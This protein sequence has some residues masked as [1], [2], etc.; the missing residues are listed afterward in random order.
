MYAKKQNIIYILF[1]TF[2]LM[3]SGCSG[4]GSSSKT[5]TE[6]IPLAD[7]N[8]TFSSIGIK[9]VDELKSKVLAIGAL[10]LSVEIQNSN[11]GA[12]VEDIV[13]LLKEN[14]RNIEYKKLEKEGVSSSVTSKL[15]A[16]PYSPVIV[17]QMVRMPDEKIFPIKNL[18]DEAVEKLNKIKLGVLNRKL[19]I[20]GEKAI[21]MDEFLSLQKAFTS[22]DIVNNFG[23]LDKKYQNILVRDTLSS[24]SKLSATDTNVTEESY[25]LINATNEANMSVNAGDFP[26]IDNKCQIMRLQLPLQVAQ[27]G[28]TIENNLVSSENGD[29]KV[30]FPETGIAVITLSDM[31]GQNVVLKNSAGDVLESKTLSQ[32][33]QYYLPITADDICKPFTF[34]GASSEYNI[35]VTDMI[36]PQRISKKVFFNG[37]HALVSDLDQLYTSSGIFSAKSYTFSTLN[38]TLQN[39]KITFETIG[40][41]DNQS[42]FDYIL[43]APGGKLY[44]ATTDA[45]VGFTELP[46]LVRETGIWRLDI[47]PKG[48]VHTGA[49][50][51]DSI[52]SI[53][54]IPDSERY[55]DLKTYID[56]DADVHTKE[57]MLGILKSVSLKT[58]GEDGTFDEGEV[59]INLNTNM[60]PIL[61]VPSYMDDIIQSG[62]TLNKDIAL[63]QCWEK[64]QK[65]GT[66][67]QSGAECENFHDEF[68][69]R[70]E[71]YET[72]HTYDYQN[73][74]ETYMC[75]D[76]DGMQATCIKGEHG[77]YNTDNPSAEYKVKVVMRD[78][79]KYMQQQYNDV[80]YL[81]ILSNY[82]DLYQNWLDRTV[83][84]DIG[85]FP[86]D[87]IPYKTQEYMPCTSDDTACIEKFVNTYT[88]PKIPVI[89]Q[90]DRPIF[91]VPVERVNESTLPIA[92]DYS[93]K[94][95]DVYNTNA[96]AFATLQ[97]MASQTLNIAT[98]NFV[99]LV[100]DTVNLADD[101]HDVELAA[102]DDPLGS[103]RVTL[104]RYTS[105]DSFY[106]LDTKDAFSFYMSGYPEKNDKVDTYGQKLRYAQIACGLSSLASSGMTFA[107]NADLLLG[108]NSDVVDN[109]ADIYNIIAETSTAVSAA[110][111]MQE[112]QEIAD[113]IHEGKIE[114]AKAR[115]KLS[116]DLNNLDKGTDIYADVDSLLSSYKDEASGANGN[117]VI[118]SNVHY[119]LGTGRKTRAD[120]EFSR[121]GSAPVESITVNLDKVKIISNYEDDDNAKIRMIPFVG[122]VGD[123]HYSST[124]IHSLFSSI[125]VADGTDEEG[126]DYL[127]F[128]HV[129]DGQTLETPNTVLYKGGYENIAALYIELAITEDDGVSVEDDDMIGVFSKTIKLEEI[130]N[131]NTQLKWTHL[132]GNDYELVI[133]DYPVYSS[134]NQLSLENPLSDDYEEQKRHN[135]KRVPSALVSLTI[136]VTLRDTSVSYPVV[137]TSLDIGAIA[138]GV[139]A[140]SMDINLVNQ[141]N[142]NDE[143]YR[144]IMDVFDD[145]ALLGL[146]AQNAGPMSILEVDPVSH[147]MQKLF[148]FDIHDFQGDLLPIKE[149]LTSSKSIAPKIYTNAQERELSMVKLLADNKLLF[150]ISHDNGA[151]LM[152]VSYTDSG[153][154]SLVD[155]TE[156]KD[157][158]NA[159]VTTALRAVLSPNRSQCIVPYIPTEYANADKKEP[160][161]TKVNLYGISDANISLLSHLNMLTG[162][163]Y[164]DSEFIDES[165]LAVLSQ[166]LLFETESSYYSNWQERQEN[167]TSEAMD[168]LYRIKGENL[169]LYNINHSYQA[170]LTDTLEHAFHKVN[171]DDL[172]TN[173][174]I[175]SLLYRRLKKLDLIS[176]VNGYYANLKLYPT[177]LQQLDY[178]ATV[179]GYFVGT[180]TSKGASSSLR[181]NEDSGYYCANGITCSGYL[182][183]ALQPWKD[184]ENVFQW[185]DADMRIKQFEFLDTKRDLVLALVNRGEPILLNLYDKNAYKGPLLSSD[186]FD[187]SIRVS[188]SDSLI[189][190]FSIADR[191]TPTDALS[192]EAS[193]STIDAPDGYDGTHISNITCVRDENNISQCSG[194]ISFDAFND[195]NTTLTQKII[196]SVSDGVYGDTAAFTIYHKPA[197]LVPFSDATHQTEVW[198]TDGTSQGTEMLDDANPNGD[199]V[200]VGANMYK[201]NEKY[202]Y[203]GITA[204]GNHEPF[205]TTMSGQSHQIDTTKEMR[206]PRNFVLLGDNVY[207]IAQY[208]SED[209]NNYQLWKTDGTA[210]GT[211]LVKD[212]S[213]V[214]S[215]S[216]LVVMDSKL[217][218]LSS[219]YPNGNLNAKLWRSDGT[220]SG[221]IMLKDELYTH[222]I[223]S[224]AGK[225]FFFNRSGS[226]YASGLWSSDG[227]ASGTEVIKETDDYNFGSMLEFEG[228]AYFIYIHD[229]DASTDY[230]DVLELWNT[231][232]SSANTKLVH[233]FGEQ[234]GDLNGFFKTD[235]RLYFLYKGAVWESDGSDSGT[236]KVV[237]YYTLPNLQQIKYSSI[238][239]AIRVVDNTI[240]MATKHYDSDAS[241]VYYK[242][243]WMDPSSS[244]TLQEVDSN[245]Y[246]S[247]SLYN[248]SIGKDF[249]FYANDDNYN[250]MYKHN[251]DD[252]ES[253][254]KKTQR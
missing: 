159:T 252:G 143:Y 84:V 63:W 206:S 45:V 27:S 128:T 149:A 173:S 42:S 22:V 213:D 146:S 88:Y 155:T 110:A 156:I 235:N 188:G 70:Q 247:V 97:F 200:W 182:S 93:T 223:Y 116:S 9:S 125:D 26:M 6:L 79:S 82:N 157:E 58:Q 114:E 170:E 2:L 41:D 50:K 40:D 48:T 51:I 219:E 111:M 35:T 18:S 194:T 78:Y 154:M 209:Y 52:S 64:S 134:P 23:N 244:S 86:Y 94:D 141:L 161:Q 214:R 108:M 240:Y 39:M 80:E 33:S 117:N 251:P 31:S 105:A 61:N 199:S 20:R 162:T 175:G 249:L 243:Y 109:T 12:K 238:E 90:V 38:S 185:H 19:R 253:L 95:Q 144:K 66:E 167:C 160:A 76:E 32:T 59:T 164:E 28:V 96:A 222:R 3:L 205:V 4:G 5:T 242:V 68:E 203:A 72:A 89:I 14:N 132:S 174:P 196:I 62:D 221:T 37:G 92:F 107:Q 57:F 129:A 75:R 46:T 169:L 225:I 81:H 181:Y 137:D 147:T 232:G 193:V 195:E 254:V 217:Y 184:K 34:E 172:N 131:K 106:G 65:T 239:E 153:Q 177:I 211:L 233:S 124:E 230:N 7:E 139:D 210:D 248:E 228:L 11:P 60:A 53:A 85:E 112:A 197:I 49:E 67:F 231:D 101:L 218:F 179:D 250:Y 216:S 136:K 98:G 208:D 133:A 1:I 189:F 54:L 36:K 192:V 47:L 241:E 246:G 145:K 220:E 71:L 126:W 135:L 55:C 56:I 123:A 150:V 30:S 120:V 191:D 151:R 13:K 138:S 227:T 229:G 234:S 176:L 83:Q 104:N 142:E 168:C 212:M 237:D 118:K 152:R 77:P 25:V 115:L 119:L 190:T 224:A 43:Y 44:S 74:P 24:A 180:R 198:M 183:S 69:R 127:W 178:D 10:P 16:L 226:S 140:L 187:T 245:R 29:A 158:N 171:K 236:V 204:D 130:F 21:T 165:H 215:I 99:N 73:N 15:K 148:T 186:M 166:D 113:L 100:C 17:K 102:Q 8:G 121:V 122:V 103:A 201:L 207:F 163:V 87:G 91:G 202:I